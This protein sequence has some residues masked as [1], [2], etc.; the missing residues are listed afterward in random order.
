[1]LGYIRLI[2]TV[3]SEKVKLAFIRLLICWYFKP[4]LDI[5]STPSDVFNAVFH[6]PLR[7]ILSTSGYV[8]NLKV[9]VPLVIYSFPLKRAKIL[10]REEARTPVHY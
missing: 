10:T 5:F 6:L 9:H 3:L 8:A 4:R 1:M 2:V 7:I